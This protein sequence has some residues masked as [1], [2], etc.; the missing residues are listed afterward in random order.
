ME[1]QEKNYY[2]ILEI[3]TNATS[4]EIQQGYGRI[5]NAYSPDGLAMYSLMSKDECNSMLERIDEAYS[6]LIDPSKRRLYD[7]S[8]NFNLDMENYAHDFHSHTNDIS[9]GGCPKT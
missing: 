4:K 1:E 2:E 8:K 6:I 3:K 7:Q 5:K 9:K